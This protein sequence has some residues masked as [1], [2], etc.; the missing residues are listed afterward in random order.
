MWEGSQGQSQGSLAGVTGIWCGVEEEAGKITWV[1]VWKIWGV[2]QRSLSFLLKAIGSHWML[3]IIWGGKLSS[4]WLLQKA[5]VNIPDKVLIWGACYEVHSHIWL[6][7]GAGV[8]R[9][10]GREWAIKYF[11]LQSRRG[12]SPLDQTTRTHSPSCEPR[13]SCDPGLAHTM[14][15]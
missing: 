4:R 3:K 10:G 14:G 6:T 11:K 8:G 12:I 15:L 13:P 9:E 5:V 1:P 2:K 7:L